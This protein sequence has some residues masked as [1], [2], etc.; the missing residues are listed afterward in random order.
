M[1][2][3]APR[4]AAM[5]MWVWVLTIPGIIKARGA[6]TRRPACLAL[7]SAAGPSEEILP[8]LTAT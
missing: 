4:K 5:E 8:S 7:P 2:S 3:Q 1:S 6:C